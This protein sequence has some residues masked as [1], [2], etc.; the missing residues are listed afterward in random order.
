[1]TTYTFDED[2]VSNLHKDAFGFR[3]S[4]GWYESWNT[5]TDAEKQ[6]EWDSL[7][8]SLERTVAQDEIDEKRAIESFGLLV[9]KTIAHGAGDVE[10]AHRW[11]ME[12]SDCDGD[13]EHLC[14]QHGLPYSYFKVAVAA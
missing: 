4:R 9:K 6:V 5:M 2:T 11:I 8:V 3:P 13:W 7:L 1:M 14:F 12:S 10:T